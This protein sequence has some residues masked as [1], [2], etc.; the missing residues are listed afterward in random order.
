MHCELHG[1]RVLIAVRDNG[2]GLPSGDRE[3]IF[4]PF[5]TTKP[6]GSGI[7]LSLARRIAVAHGGT[8][9]VRVQPSGLLMLMSL[10]LGG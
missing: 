8:L 7:G 3:Q 5:F 1:Q 4:V 9:D 6:D 2:V 10:P